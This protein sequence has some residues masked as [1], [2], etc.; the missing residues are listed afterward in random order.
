MESNQAVP[1]QLRAREIAPE[2][3]GT[4]VMTHLHSDHASGIAHFP[5]ATFVISADEWE[6]ARKG[7]QLDGYLKR[8]YDHAFDYRLV[9]FDGPG[10]GS[11][12]TFGRALD[13]FG[14]G[15][16]QLVSTPGHT[17]GHL[18]V[19]LRLAHREALIAGDAL[20]HDAHAARPPPARTGWPTSTASSAPCARSSSTPSRRPTPW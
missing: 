13:L 2:S 1:P 8:Q 10:A 11:F 20:V 19:V 12:A 18:S 6:S 17:E 3:V 16:V 15:S 14:D 5:E 4:I 7:S 9:D